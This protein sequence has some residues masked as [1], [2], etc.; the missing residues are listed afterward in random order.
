MRDDRSEA[1]DRTSVREVREIAKRAGGRSGA[2][3]A[4]FTGSDRELVDNAV[5]T[6]A[7]ESDRKVQRID[8]RQ[9]VSK[10]AGETEK[11]LERIFTDAER[12]GAVLVFDEAD[13]LFGREPA[14]GGAPDGDRILE[15]L[16]ARKE[17]LAGAIVVVV[18]DAAAVDDRRRKRFDYVVP[19][20]RT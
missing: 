6:I 12:S 9:L 8:L 14:K 1:H 17:R 3:L 20:D 15:F 5:S 2:A 13:A 11:N 10:Y 4:L 16:A 19:F 7:N 18:T